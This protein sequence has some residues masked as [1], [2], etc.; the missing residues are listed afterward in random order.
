MDRSSGFGNATRESP[1]AIT[2]RITQIGLDPAGS[3]RALAIIA[4]SA[5]ASITGAVIFNALLARVGSEN[6]S[7]YFSK[8]GIGR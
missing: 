2:K 7:C 3:A 5:R 8:T 4:Q 1:R 6:K